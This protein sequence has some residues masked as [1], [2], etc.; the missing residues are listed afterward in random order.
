[1]AS[2][3]LVTSTSIHN[4]VDCSCKAEGKSDKLSQR[5]ESTCQIQNQ[6]L[7]LVCIQYKSYIQFSVIIYM[8]S[9]VYNIDIL[10]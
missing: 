7:S 9:H 3:K 5:R 4:V 2:N 1:M 6:I 10:N 8:Y